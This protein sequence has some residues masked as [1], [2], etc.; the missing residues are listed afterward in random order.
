MFQQFDDVLNEP[1][2]G[3]DLRKLVDPRLGDDYPLDSVLKVKQLIQ[4][5]F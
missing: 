4:K 5:P 2:P 1:N 3:E